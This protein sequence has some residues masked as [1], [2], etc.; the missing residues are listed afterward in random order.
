MF[1]EEWSKL[2]ER[3]LEAL[4]Q[5]YD[6]ITQNQVV[7]EGVHK[8]RQIKKLPKDYQGPV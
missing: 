1:S 3:K 2:K 6:P 4:K 5:K 7:P 8:K